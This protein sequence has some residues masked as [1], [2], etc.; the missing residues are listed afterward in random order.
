[1]RRFAADYLDSLFRQ[2]LARGDLRPDL[3]TPTVIFLLDAL[4]DRFLQAASV[5]A[6]DVT[7]GLDQAG[8]AELHQRVREL[9]AILRHGLGR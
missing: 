9:V 6:F 2:G 7:L 4:L 1:V 5:P 8:A 3:P